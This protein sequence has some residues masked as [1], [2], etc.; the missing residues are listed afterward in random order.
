MTTS[1]TPTTN[2]AAPP[3][4]PRRRLRGL[5]AAAAVLAPVLIWILAVPVLGT[6]LLV[7]GRTAGTSTKIGLGEVLFI[8]V[9]SVAAGWALLAVLERWWS[10]AR[11][12]WA[13]IATLVLL[14]SFA[15]LLSAELTGSA[16][17]I[18]GLMHLAVGLTL[19]PPLVRTSPRR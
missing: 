8:S 11:T 7:P 14:L 18:L 19:I 13:I 12:G 5:A 9:L 15:P 17:L 2:D 3:V 6:E 16:R 1:I 4:A 10:R